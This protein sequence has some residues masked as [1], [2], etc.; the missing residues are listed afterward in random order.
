MRDSL[1]AGWRTRKDVEV[2]PRNFIVI[3]DEFCVV[4]EGFEVCERRSGVVCIAGYGDEAVMAGSWDCCS[5]PD[6]L[7]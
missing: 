2:A 3:L 7:G 5:R 6:K 4:I 1:F